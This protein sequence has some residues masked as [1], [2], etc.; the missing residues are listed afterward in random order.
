MR[1]GF[2]LLSL[3][4]LSVIGCGGGPS[5]LPDIGAVSGVI[6]VDGAPQANLTI[7]FQPEGGR[8]ASGTTDAQGYYTLVY[9]RDYMGTKIGKNLVTISAPEAPENY[10][11]GAADNNA[12]RES[13]PN[14]IPAKYN[15][16]AFENPEMSVEV[17]A[18]DNT[19]NWDISTKG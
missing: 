14:A 6:K 13:A 18:G 4:L 8:P 19:F 17:Q 16:M 1:A 9:S 10:E 5:D 11:N 12:A 2:C 3:C 15:T 7:A